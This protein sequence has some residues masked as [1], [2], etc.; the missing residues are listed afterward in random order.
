M[1]IA[2]QGDGLVQPLTESE[3]RAMSAWLKR[4]RHSKHGS[5]R[6][7]HADHARHRRHLLQGP[8]AGPPKP[9]ASGLPP[10]APQL[11]MGPVNALSVTYRIAALPQPVRS[12]PSLSYLAASNYC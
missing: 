6:N 12:K 5:D 1:A 7:A 4:G 2:A 11:G 8:P 3:R 10:D 9:A